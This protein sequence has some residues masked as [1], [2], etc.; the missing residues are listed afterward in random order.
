[1]LRRRRTLVALVVLLFLAVSAVLARV[2][3]VEGQER[4]AVLQV[5]RAQA[6]GDAEAVLDRLTACDGPCARAVRAATARV[7]GPGDVKL[8]RLDSG[9]SY[10]LGTSQGTSR[11]VWVRGEDGRPVVQCFQVRREGSVLTDRST[12]LLRVGPPLADNEAPC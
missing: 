10:A 12:S 5:L 8:V 9:T 6:R 4:E 2:L 3:S 11:V 7:A 1:M